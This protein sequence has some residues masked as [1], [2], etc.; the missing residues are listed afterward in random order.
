MNRRDLIKVAL[1]IPIAVNFTYAKEGNEF[2]DP[3]TV[4]PRLD[5]AFATAK[6]L[7]KNNFDKIA[8]VFMENSELCAVF[9]GALVTGL[10]MLG[11]QAWYIEGGKDLIPSLKKYSPDALYMAYF[12]ELPDE[13][14]Q[15]ALN[16]DLKQLAGYG[17]TFK[18]V[19][20][21]STLQRGYVGNAIFEED[22]YNYL[23]DNKALYAIKVIEGH[24]YLSKVSELSEFGISF[25]ENVDKIKLIRFAEVK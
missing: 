7:E 8:V 13:E 12:G 15:E 16:R 19:F 22:I 18:V 4:N 23:K 10:R 2:I 5:V 17:K 24:V 11:K 21:V 1:L 14:V 20:H 25:G 6:L 9:A 3:K